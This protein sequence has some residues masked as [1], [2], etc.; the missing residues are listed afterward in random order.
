MD[1]AASVRESLRQRSWI[2]VG[3]EASLSR[4]GLVQLAGAVSVLTGS[5]LLQPPPSLAKSALAPH[6]R[7]MLMTG[8]DHL[9]GTIT[10][11]CKQGGC[12]GCV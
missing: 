4:R 6:S 10:F 2:L 7:K 12:T 8:L 3:A 11:G 9:W 1:V 5:Q